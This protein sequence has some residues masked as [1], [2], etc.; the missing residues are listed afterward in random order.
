M[1]TCVAAFPSKRD[2]RGSWLLKVLK[3]DM[4]AIGLLVQKAQL[5]EA[6]FGPHIEFQSYILN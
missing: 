2:S 1:L 6:K 4:N 5:S 3:E